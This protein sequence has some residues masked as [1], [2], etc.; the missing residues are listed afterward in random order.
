MQELLYEGKKLLG[1][2]VIFTGPLPAIE[3]YFQMSDMFIHGSETE[4]TPNALLEAMACGLACAIRKLPGISGFL[5]QHDFN[6]IEFSSFGEIPKIIDSLR[7]FP[8][9]ALD[10]G[11]K[12]NQTIT[13]NY[14]FE[15][16][17]AKLFNRL[18]GKT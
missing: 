9:K 16:V 1:E 7:S 8:Q 5:V 12:A 6:A 3:E 2:K 17:A 15:I 4:G 10:L 18:H 14:T 11:K 13:E